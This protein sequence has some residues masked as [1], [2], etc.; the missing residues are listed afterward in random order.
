ML[1]D[2]YRDNGFDEAEALPWW[3]QNFWP[4]EAAAWS[5]YGFDPDEAAHWHDELMVWSAEAARAMQDAGMTDTEVK[6]WRSRAPFR[7]IV[8]WRKLG[9]G[10]ERR[11]RWIRH[12]YHP[13]DAAYWEARGRSPAPAREPTQ[14]DPV[15]L[16]LSDYTA[17]PTAGVKRFVHRVNGRPVDHPNGHPAVVELHTDGRVAGYVHIPDEDGLVSDPLPGVP[18]EA[19]FTESGELAAVFHRQSGE[20][21]DAGSAPAVAIYQDGALTEERRYNHGDRANGTRGEPAVVRTVDGTETHIW[22]DGTNQEITDFHE[23]A[24]RPVAE[25]PETVADQAA[26]SSAPHT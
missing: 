23:Q 10:Y 19:T 20:L 26:S 5:N 2:N 17:D 8:G 7:E 6:R 15:D 21:H 4:G 9:I 22:L 3:E 16:D 13:A 25:V 12:G 18:A 14:P 24:L 1:L 11:E